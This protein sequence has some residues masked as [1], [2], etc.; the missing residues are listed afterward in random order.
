MLLSGT[1]ST[2][3]FYCRSAWTIHQLLVS[4]WRINWGVYHHGIPGCF[5]NVFVNFSEACLK[6]CAT[7]RLRIAWLVDWHQSTCFEA[8][9]CCILVLHLLSLLSMHL[10][11]DC[12][13]LIISFLLYKWSNKPKVK[14]HWV[15]RK[16]SKY[17]SKYS[18]TRTIWSSE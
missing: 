12:T 10:F 8:T 15:F 9:S 5:L 18:H 4:A 14:E 11:G 13:I 3:L 7:S 16:T 2:C 6:S 17:T 1:D